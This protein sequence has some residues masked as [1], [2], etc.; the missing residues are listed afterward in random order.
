MGGSQRGAT[1]V[2][3]CSFS[4]SSASGDIRNKSNPGWTEGNKTPSFISNAQSHGDDWDKENKVASSTIAQN[5]QI[6]ISKSG[7]RTISTKNQ[8]DLRE[9]LN[10]KRNR[11]VSGESWHSSGSGGSTSTN[12]MN[13]V[14]GSHNKQPIISVVCLLSSVLFIRWNVS[15][16]FRL[17]T[18][19]RLS[20]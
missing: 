14:D 8:V 5:L 13:R 6:G 1:S 2:G 12:E 20:D 15:G 19:F 3:I 4:C 16:L 7:E 9:F 10:D 18:D 11:H 17:N